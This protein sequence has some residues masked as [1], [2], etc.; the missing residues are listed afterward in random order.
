MNVTRM[1]REQLTQ[2][3]HTTACADYYHLEPG[4][5]T[6]YRF[7]IMRPGT[8]VWLGYVFDSG[9][10]MWPDNYIFISINMPGGTGVTCVMDE[11]LKL[12]ELPATYGYCRGHGMAH[13]DRY[14]LMAV[15]LAAS[16][17]ASK[18]SD[19]ERACDAMRQAALYLA[20]V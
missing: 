18:P 17:L 7:S 8:D 16:V 19:I 20:Q 3:Q 2:A 1:M 6:S 5:G 4:D 11:Q 15:L 9:L 12:P 13:V 10:G 14:T